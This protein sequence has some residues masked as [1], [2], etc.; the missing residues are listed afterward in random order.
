MFILTDFIWMIE[1]TPSVRPRKR[2]TSKI[3][4][5]HLRLPYFWKWYTPIDE[6]LVHATSKCETLLV[7]IGS[8]GRPSDDKNGWSNWDDT[9]LKNL[10]KHN[11]RHT[12]PVVHD[13]FIYLWISTN[14]W[15]I[16]FWGVKLLNSRSH[17]HWDIL[18]ARDPAS[19]WKTPDFPACTCKPGMKVALCPHQ[20]QQ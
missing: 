18:L 11:N 6:I 17:L 10:N 13:L 15:S 20:Q 19:H 3:R 5:P 7:V 12:K 2:Q 14:K 9:L 1:S 8:N 16:I 4:Q